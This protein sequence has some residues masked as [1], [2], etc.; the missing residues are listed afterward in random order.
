MSCEVVN[1]S[2]FKFLSEFETC[3]FDFNFTCEFRAVNLGFYSFSPIAPVRG[4]VKLGGDIYR[5][6]IPLKFTTTQGAT[7][8]VG[9]LFATLLNSPLHRGGAR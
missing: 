9:R 6:Y 2:Y 3:E 4:A 1:L 7:G 8:A 5:R